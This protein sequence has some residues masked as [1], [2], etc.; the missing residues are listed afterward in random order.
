MADLLEPLD[1]IITEKLLPAL[2]GMTSISE[3]E[4]RLFALPTRNGGLGMPILG[5]IAE[6]EFQASM[7]MTA[8]LAT[9]MALQSFELPDPATVSQCQ[10]SVK[11]QKKGSRETH[12]RI[13]R[14]RAGGNHPKSC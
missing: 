3:S 11:A 13:C 7:Q 9:I 2:T 6:Y 14:T 5:E 12:C 10:N 1:R 4:R 8:P